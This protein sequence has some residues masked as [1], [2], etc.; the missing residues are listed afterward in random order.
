MPRGDKSKYTDKQ[1]RK[2]DHIAEGYEKR[3]VP[4]R[5]PSGAPGPP[6]TRTTAAARSRADQDEARTPDIRQRTKAAALAAKLPLRG[7]QPPGRRQPRRQR[8]PASVADTNF[9]Q[10][11][12][13]A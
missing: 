3:G 6:S 9:T 2:A 7:P 5:K 10:S 13:I 11:A 8:Q 1:E 12:S 4:R